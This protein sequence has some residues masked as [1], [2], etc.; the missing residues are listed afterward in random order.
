MRVPTLS[1]SPAPA[2]AAPACMRLGPRR[3]RRR[4]HAP[5]TKVQL[6]RPL[7]V[8]GQTGYEVVF[9]LSLQH[10]AAG[11]ANPLSLNTPLPR[12]LAARVLDRFGRRALR[13]GE[14]ARTRSR[15]WALPMGQRPNGSTRRARRCPRRSSSSIRTWATA[16]S[17]RPRACCRRSSAGASRAAG[18][19]TRRCRTRCGLTSRKSSASSCQASSWRRCSCCACFRCGSRGAARTAAARRRARRTAASTR[20]RRAAAAASGASP[21]SC[22][23]SSAC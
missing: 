21:R 20:G 17:P 11:A 5:L 23:S 10:R 1:P 14:T 9:H 15:Q 12:R 22:A 7:T 2:V 6:L 4:P 13:L 16:A 8:R 18:R 3:S 19:T